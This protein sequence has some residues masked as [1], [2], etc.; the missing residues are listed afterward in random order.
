M[1]MSMSVPRVRELLL[2]ELFSSDARPNSGKF[3]STQGR[4]WL[5]HKPKSRTIIWQCKLLDPKP[6]ML[7]PKP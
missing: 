7:N 4:C 6:L 1:T 2:T 5:N 3:I